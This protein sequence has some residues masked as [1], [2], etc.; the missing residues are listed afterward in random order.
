MRLRSA[1]RALR[2]RPHSATWLP[3]PRTALNYPYANLYATDPATRLIPNVALRR[4]LGGLYIGGGEAPPYLGAQNNY[5]FNDGLTKHEGQPTSSAP[6]SSPKSRA[7]TSSLP[8]TITDQSRPKTTP[9][10][11]GN[12]WADLLLGYTSNFSQS[13]A[14]LLANM[15]AQALR[16]LSS[17]MPG[18]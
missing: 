6:V 17:R 10:R 15:S 7:T 5:T 2:S 14:N 13:S 16:L 4:P 12:D 1:T 11:T 8:A 9:R 18:R 3:S